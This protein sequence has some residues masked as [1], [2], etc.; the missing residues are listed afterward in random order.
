[1]VK[2]GER[3]CALLTSGTSD[4]A[5]IQGRLV[6]STIVALIGLALIGLVLSLDLTSTHRSE[7]HFLI[8]M[9]MVGSAR[10][11]GV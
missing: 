8:F 6:A 4:N 11:V 9:Q 5:G 1:M 2:L 7:H 3:L 10:L